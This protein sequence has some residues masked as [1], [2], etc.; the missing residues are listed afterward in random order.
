[1][2]PDPGIPIRRPVF[3]PGRILDAYAVVKSAIRSRSASHRVA[4]SMNSEEILR[5]FER[6]NVWKRSGELAPHKPLLVLYALG[7]WQRGLTEVRFREAEDDLR[8]LLRE[9]GPE[10]KSDHPEEPFWRLQNDGVWTVDAPAGLIFKAGHPIPRITELRSYN[11]RAG[12]SID[13][14]NALAD[15]ENLLGEIA[16][17]MLEPHFPVALRERILEA[18]GLNPNCRSRSH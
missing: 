3:Y 7:R 10:R 18:V 16:S 1:M 9:F 2:P 17:R 12:F 5:R 15:D 11:V 6:L 14:L 4:A 13:V 8:R